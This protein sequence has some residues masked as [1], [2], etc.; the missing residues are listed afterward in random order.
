MDSA[1]VS[2]T[3]WNQNTCLLKDKLVQHYSSSSSSTQK[4]SE[5]SCTF[6][7]NAVFKTYMYMCIYIYIYTHISIYI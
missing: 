7:S 3:T 1:R 6:F 5:V 4:S 2:A